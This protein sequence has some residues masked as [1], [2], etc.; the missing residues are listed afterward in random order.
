MSISF[1][2]YAIKSKYQDKSKEELTE[3]QAE[4]QAQ[5]DTATA[6]DAKI[7]EKEIARIFEAIALIDSTEAGDI[8]GVER[9]LFSDC[10]NTPNCDCSRCETLRRKDLH[11]SMKK[12]SPFYNFFS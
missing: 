3:M 4:L 1:E 10:K 9:N 11:E 2:T 5:L 7:I 6:G 8:A 12:Q